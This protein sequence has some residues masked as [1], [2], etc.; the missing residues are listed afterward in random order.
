VAGRFGAVTAQ[1]AVSQWAEMHST[2]EGRGSCAV[3]SRHPRLNS[4]S[5]IAFIGD[6]RPTNNTGIV[7][8]TT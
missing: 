4:L 6:P 2:P 1:P 3:T 7:C 5:S 8:L